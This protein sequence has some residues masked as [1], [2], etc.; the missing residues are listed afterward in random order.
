MSHFAIEIRPTRRH[1]PAK[2]NRPAN[3][4]TFL[5]VVQAS[6]YDASGRRYNIA[7]S[8][9]AQLDFAIRQVRGL[10]GDATIEVINQAVLPIVAQ[11]VPMSEEDTFDVLVGRD[12]VFGAPRA[13]EADESA[14][15]DDESEDDG[16]PF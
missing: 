3:V 9:R 4:Q 15:D 12:R 5:D 13:A 11:V 16:E 8:T 14:A 7:P 10:K 6:E 2:G 1:Y